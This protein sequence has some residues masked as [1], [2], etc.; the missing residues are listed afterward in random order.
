MGCYLVVI[1]ICISQVINLHRLPNDHLCKGLCRASG[2]PLQRH[3]ETGMLESI[4]KDKVGIKNEKKALSWQQW[5]RRER[6]DGRL[7]GREGGRGHAGREV[8]WG[9]HSGRGKAG[10]SLYR[11]KEAGYTLDDAPLRGPPPSLSSVVW[12]GSARAKGTPDYHMRNVNACFNNRKIAKRFSGESK[13]QKRRPENRTKYHHPL[14]TPPTKNPQGKR[15]TVMR[16]KV[17]KRK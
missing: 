6:E 10:R 15:K 13:H 9:R 1:F 12:V 11:A 5:K 4:K 7:A 2:S 16:L 3:H 17:Q 8:L 14:L